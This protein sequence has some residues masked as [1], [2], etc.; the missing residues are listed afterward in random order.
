MSRDRT[1]SVTR[2]LGY[3]IGDFGFNLYWSTLSL[4]VLYYYTDVIGIPARTAGLIILIALVW[5]GI[6]DPLMGYLAERTR[7]RWGSYRPYL[8]FGGPPLAASL[9]LM[10]YKPD[11]AGAALVLYAAVT[12]LGRCRRA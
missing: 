7:T 5:D 4:F 8:L 11:M 12:H 10:F 9:M 1:L 6:T 2:M 3:G